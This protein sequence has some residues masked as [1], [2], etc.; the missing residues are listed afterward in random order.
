M[1]PKNLDEQEE[2]ITSILT[3]IPTHILLSA[4]VNMPVCLRKHA[5]NPGKM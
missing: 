3:N 1:K 4:I 2:R 5:D